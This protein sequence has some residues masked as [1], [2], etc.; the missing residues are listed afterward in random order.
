VIG[1]GTLLFGAI[2][3][4]ARAFGRWNWLPAAM[5]AYFFGLYPFTDGAAPSIVRNTV[6]GEISAVVAY[7]LTF[8]VWSVGWVLLAF[9]LWSRPPHSTAPAPPVT[10][11][12]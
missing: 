4:R 10:P 2:A 5:G 12:V 8:S 7:L 9:E 1:L 3:L 11:A 6:P